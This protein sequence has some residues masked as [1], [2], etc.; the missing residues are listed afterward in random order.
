M[1]EPGRQAVGDSAEPGL[2]TVRFR[3]SVAMG[4]P[5][6]DIGEI[7]RPREGEPAEMTV[8]F[9]GLA[10]CFGPL[11]MPYTELLLERAQLF[12]DTAMRDFLDVFNHRLVSLMHG[13]R[14]RHR[15]GFELRSPE[16]S[17]VAAYLFSLIGLGTRGLRERMDVP[18][19]SL[20]FY[21]GLLGARPRS[22]LGLETMLADFF[23]VAVRGVGMRGRWIELEP[24]QITRLGPSGQNRTLGSTAALGSR[25][26]DQQGGFE[27]RIGPMPFERFADFLPDGDAYAP[28]IAMTRFYAG[29]EL[30]VTLLLAPMPHTVPGARLGAADGARLGWTSWLR[31]GGEASKLPPVRLMLTQ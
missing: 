12:K 9:M 23:G 24:D 28:L 30:A 2:E 25:A 11:P 26:W 16:Q 17:N 21:A 6:S 4:F 13:V 31:G 14:K 22:M 18:D 7:R 8:N 10:G 1:L 27:L 20:L 19:R 29:D 5:A 15:V 3:S